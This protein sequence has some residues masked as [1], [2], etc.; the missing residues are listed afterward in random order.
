MPATP[1]YA[2][3]ADGIAAALQDVITKG[4]DPRT[5]LAKY[6]DDWNAKYAGK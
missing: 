1:Y 5:I 4:Q 2:Q 6:G 3:L